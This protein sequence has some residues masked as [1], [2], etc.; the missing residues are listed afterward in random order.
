M[1]TTKEFGEEIT[2]VDTAR[3]SRFV[4]PA[5]RSHTNGRTF[6]RLSYTQPGPYVF[7]SSTKAGRPRP[8]SLSPSFPALR[9]RA[10]IDTP[11]IRNTPNSLK[12]KESNPF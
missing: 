2:K 9:S 8:Y 12:T 1:C 10:L 5:R 3:A 11:A 6:F 4:H 7:P